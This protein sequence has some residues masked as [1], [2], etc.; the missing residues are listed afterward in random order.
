MNKHKRMPLF[1][2]QWHGSNLYLCGNETACKYL[3][4]RILDGIEL[5]GEKTSDY[6]ID[7]GED[8][9]EKSY[10]H[11]IFI[12]DK[13][14]HES[15]YKRFRGCSVSVMTIEQAYGFTKSQKELHETDWLA[16]RAM[17]RLFLSLHEKKIHSLPDSVLELLLNRQKLRSNVNSEMLIENDS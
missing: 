14:D 17:E 9:P 11:I 16:I 15:I 6:K 10:D 5:S 2:D 8:K 7:F 12:A 4:L 1:P 13:S 3:S